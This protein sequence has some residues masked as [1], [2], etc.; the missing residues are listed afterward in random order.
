MIRLLRR[1]A[2]YYGYFSL[3]AAFAICRLFT[4]DATFRRFH[5]LQPPDT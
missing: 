1:H 4:P 3:D 2:A 5:F